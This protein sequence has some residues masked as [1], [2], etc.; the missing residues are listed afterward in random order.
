MNRNADYKLK[1]LKNASGLDARSKR[2]DQLN[3]NRRLAR[4]AK[5]YAKRGLSEIDT[6]AVD[7]KSPKAPVVEESHESRLKE[8][9]AKLKLWREK[10]IVA[11]EK[12]KAQKKVPFIVPGISRLDKLAKEAKAS[13]KEPTKPAASRP[14][15]G[16]ETRTTKAQAREPT[17]PAANWE[18]TAIRVTRSQTKNAEKTGSNW[19]VT[20]TKTT[21]V[22]NDSQKANTEV[23]SFAP[24][25]FVFTAPTGITNEVM[26]YQYQPNLDE[27]TQDFFVKTHTPRKAQA[28]EAIEKPME[29]VK[30]SPLLANNPWITMT[31]GSSSSKLRKSQCATPA[32]DNQSSPLLK[33]RSNNANKPVEAV[34][35]CEQTDQQVI[36]LATLEIN[37]DAE[38]FRTLIK[39]EDFRLKELCSRWD[40]LLVS[41]DVPEEETG[42]VRTVIGQAQLLQRERFTQFAGLVDQFENKSAEKE[43]TATDLEGFWEMIY[44]QVSD[45][46]RKF[47]GLSHLHA[48]G[49]VKEEPVEVEKKNK[50]K[51][52]VAAARPVARPAKSNMRALIAAARKNQMAAPKSPKSPSSISKRRSSSVFSPARTPGKRQSLRRSLLLG[53]SAKKTAFIVT[54]ILK[55]S[56]DSDNDAES[57]A[58]FSPG[59]PRAQLTPSHKTYGKSHDAVESV[60]P[61]ERL[62]A[63]FDALKSD[64][65]SPFRGLGTPAKTSSQFKVQRKKLSSIEVGE[66]YSPRRSTRKSRARTLKSSPMMTDASSE[67]TGKDLISFD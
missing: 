58:S 1:S 15:V 42:S 23:P 65:L 9:L 29:E 27:S 8:R 30:I 41:N 4:Q 25:N 11:E 54:E 50:P 57:C 37:A 45:V 62:S 34:S 44:L 33:R 22:K 35:S 66:C 12:A 31:R 21:A 47:E 46:D 16:R 24:K 20:A 13:N 49:W 59:L 48:N 38:R 28:T 5:S 36:P 2:V 67:D 17:N 32:H 53:S 61:E 14:K 3:D 10:K 56:K 64:A 7:L 52:K 26:K 60:S 63:A 55:D 39:T 40:H 19:I 18:K 51:K 43:I 6:N